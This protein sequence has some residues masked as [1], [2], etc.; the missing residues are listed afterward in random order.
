MYAR[1]QKDKFELIYDFELINE[2]LNVIKI[3]SKLLKGE[4]IY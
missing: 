4:K 1:R 3:L 2:N